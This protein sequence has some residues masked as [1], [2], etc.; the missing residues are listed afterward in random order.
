[1]DLL[2]EYKEL[3]YHELDFCDRL[4]NKINN[5]IAII[6]IIGGGEI[7]VWKDCFSKNF[8]LLY[9]IICILSFQCF[10]ITL[11]KFYKSYSGY[12]YAYYPISGT[13]T[14]IDNTYKIIKNKN[15]DKSIADSH[16]AKILS[17]NFIE[18]AIINRNQNILKANAHR[19]L[20]KWMIITSISIF[21]AF[22]YYVIRNSVIINSLV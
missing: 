4:N 16:I 6:T 20:N 5:T 3:Y 8:N 19:K 21:V 17:S 2:N 1:M 13:K 18:A 11:F 14:A 9:F 7:I 15:K 12:K 10:I 22:S